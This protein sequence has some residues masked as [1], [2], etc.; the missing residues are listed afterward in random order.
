MLWYFHNLLEA[1][2]LKNV[3]LL[4]SSVLV[5]YPLITV[6]FFHLRPKANV[7]VYSSLLGHAA[8][9]LFFFALQRS[10]AFLMRRQT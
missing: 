2:E 8:R 7:A 1:E 4:P 10:R 3:C 9:L 5:E 6:P